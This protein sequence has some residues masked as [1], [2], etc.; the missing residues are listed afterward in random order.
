MIIVFNCP[1][2]A[3]ILRMKEQ[4]GG[5]RGRC[6][7]CQG[8]ITVPAIETDAGMDLMPL[9]P[10]AAVPGPT[11]MTPPAAAP[12]L[13]IESRFRTLA[14][15]MATEA[16]AGA[17]SPSSTGDSN[18]GLA[19]VDDSPL[20]AKARPAT[21][22]ALDPPP[23][24][25][26]AT[27]QKESGSKEPGPS[28]STIGLA[29]VDDGPTPAA[30]APPPPPAP[31]KPASSKPD[32]E[33]FGLAPLEDA[34]HKPA[35]VAAATNGAVSSPAATKAANGA[36]NAPVADSKADV[37]I[38]VLCDGCGAKMRVPPTAAGRQLACPR[39]KKKLRVPEA[40]AVAA[41]AKTSDARPLQD[42]PPSSSSNL[43]MG[44]LDEMEGAGVAGETT[45]APL[46]STGPKGKAKGKANAGPIGQSKS[47][48]LLGMPPMVVYVG[49]VGGL[50]LLVGGLATVYF[51]TK[52]AAAPAPTPSPVAVVQTPI[53]GTPAPTP[54]KA[55]APSGQPAVPNAAPPTPGAAPQSSVPTAPP[56]VTPIAGPTTNPGAPSAAPGTPGATLPM[57]MPAAPPVVE[58]VEWRNRIPVVRLTGRFKS[59][60]APELA[61]NEVAVELLTVPL[62]SPRVDPTPAE[63]PVIL[64]VA[65]MIINTQKSI[66][67]QL[68]QMTDLAKTKQHANQWA[69]TTSQGLE[70]I[71]KVNRLSGVSLPSKDSA[72]KFDAMLNEEGTVMSAQAE[73]ERLARIPGAIEA[74]ETALKEKSARE[75]NSA[76][77]ETLKQSASQ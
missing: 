73:L 13:S 37:R 2:C 70:Q 65:P 34:P 36:P 27:A 5:Q 64:Q 77:A 63:I 7:Q 60:R 47:N 10:A 66:E 30:K 53:A 12:L 14:S 11:D 74:L 42:A 58:R 32:D 19:P 69:E 45:A 51:V 21:P 50:L 4:Y 59:E 18:I 40:P 49:A 55:P 35:A 16:A 15:S 75:P 20:S 28:D 26:K 67:A 6:P 24:A 8:A 3:A 29:P 68:K 44:M 31:A 23:R 56:A 57:P 72:I 43:D 39:C 25:D 52:P 76:L 54:G 61:E 1:H 41:L 38:T 17:A 22:A 71:R 46:K 33:N 48:T 9:D 62:A